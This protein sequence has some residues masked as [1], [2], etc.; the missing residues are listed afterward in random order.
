MKI[1]LCTQRK[2]PPGKRQD[3]FHPLPP[4]AR[5]DLVS[6]IEIEVDADVIK[7]NDKTYIKTN[8]TFGGSPVFKQAT[9]AKIIAP[10]RK[11]CFGP[12]STPHGDT[13]QNCGIHSGSL[14]GDK[15][16]RN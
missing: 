7:F 2:F 4:E 1:A 15:E 12:P 11:H 6:E 13:C 10:P 16:C 5:Y 3:G 9:E 14:D 8:E